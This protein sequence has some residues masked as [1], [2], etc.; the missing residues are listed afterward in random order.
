MSLV[1][2]VE[3]PGPAALVLR[4]LAL[5]AER[6]RIARPALVVEQARR[7][8]NLIEQVPL[9]VVAERAEDVLVPAGRQVEQARVHA[10]GQG[11]AVACA[12][13]VLDDAPV[14]GVVV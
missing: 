2:L 14:V 7:N 10:R 1:I 3:A 5:R 11:G 13:Q 8:E 6:V 9:V 4:L 12:A